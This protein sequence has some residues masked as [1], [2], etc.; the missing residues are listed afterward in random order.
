M[1]SSLR[2]I[3]N[4]MQFKTFEILKTTIILFRSGDNIL[5]SKPFM[6]GYLKNRLS[7]RTRTYG[8][9]QRILHNIL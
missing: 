4:H 1:I 3:H 8:I 7:T 9:A 2:Q 5:H 6:N